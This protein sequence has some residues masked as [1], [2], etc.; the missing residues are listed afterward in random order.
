MKGEA[1]ETKGRIVQMKKRFLGLFMCCT[2]ALLPVCSFASEVPSALSVIY[3]M[4][5]N[6]VKV[7]SLP[8]ARTS[9]ITYIV[10]D[11]YFDGLQL[12]VSVTQV[13]NDPGAQVY[14]E[15]VYELD[16]K[17]N[18]FVLGKNLNLKN[19]QVGSYC[20]VTAYGEDKK[21]VMGSGGKSGPEGNSLVQTDF[22]YFLPH[23]IRDTVRVVVS[24]GV[25]ETVVREDEDLKLENLELTIP[26]QIKAETK[27]V[28]IV[29][30]EGIL[31]IEEVFVAQTDE[32]A[33]VFI[34]YA[35]DGTGN[36]VPPFSFVL[37]GL[38]EVYEAS[39]Y[40]NDTTRGMNYDFHF[41]RTTEHLDF[42]RVKSRITQNMEYVIDIQS[43]TITKAE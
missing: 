42:I 20:Y 33:S 39:R 35:G 8:G 9:G 31:P 28:K 16:A 40:G 25:V 15:D 1:Y 36:S 32:F 30:N 41:L 29:Q 5:E 11:V 10:H 23:E 21:E 37:D 26:S 17:Q 14:E 6:T 19:G 18:V 34:Y 24:C 22:F 38:E 4:P 27:T 43:G 7:V 2:L 13:A 12:Q 3:P